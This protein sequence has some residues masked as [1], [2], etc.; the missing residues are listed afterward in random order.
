MHLSRSRRSFLK[1]TALGA[2]ALAWPLRS[3]LAFSG[4]AELKVGEGVADTTPPL[5][6]E[7][8]GFHRP[9]GQE[10]RI[11]G[12]RRPTAAR[13]LVLQIDDVQA[14]IVSLD[15][16]AVSSTMTARVQQQIAQQLGIPAAHIRLCAT[17][18]HS[19][20][21][22]CYLRQWGALSPEY[23]AT[24]EQQI[25]QA[26][27]LAQKDLAPATLAVGKSRVSGA[28]NNREKKTWESKAWKTDEQFTKDSNDEERW[29]DTMLHVLHFER[30]QGKRDL[31]WYHFSAH[32]VCYQDEQ[33]GPDWPGLVEEL[34]REKLKLTPS[35]LQ[36]HCGDVNAGNAQEWIGSE[37]NTAEPVAAAIAQAI[38]AARP[39]TVDELRIETQQF[40]VPLDID[41]FR[42][43]LEEYRS[44]PTKCVE[45]AWVDPGF[46]A[47]W[48]Q[49]SLKRDLSQT[50]LPTPL[51]VLRLG[52]VGMVFH[53]AELYS[54]YGLTIRRDSPLPDTLVVGYADDIIGYL[55]DP[56]AYQTQEYAATTVPK[57]LDL[58]PFTPHAARELSAASIAM[59]NQIV[60]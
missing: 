45:G 38:S 39:V 10:R 30:G 17:H 35:F 56:Y 40:S 20:P 13:A 36:G 15:I 53:P 60:G 24:V 8:G 19:M 27:D 52:D 59:L 22:F 55:P 41:L 6:I 50:H 12:I 11:A 16:C 7:L 48:Y 34:V 54:C 18:T 43:W 2:A 32:P 47:D 44:D 58:P 33:A 37:R 28:S 25:V 3:S 29:L 46:A 5:G 31:L 1:N 26:V 51:S 57:I 42:R 23:M 9:A 4:K 49:G 21:G 14:A